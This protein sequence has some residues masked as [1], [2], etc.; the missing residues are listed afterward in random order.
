MQ[1]LDPTQVP[2]DTDYVWN[3]ATF[4]FNSSTAVAT[5][6]DTSSGLQWTSFFDG[7]GNV[8]VQDNQGNSGLIP[9]AAVAPYSPTDGNTCLNAILTAVLIILIVLAILIAIVIVVC[10]ISPPNCARAVLW[11]EIVMGLLMCRLSNYAAAA[12]GLPPPC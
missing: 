11:A 1:M 3:G 10:R 6:T 2:F 12:C 7:N 9:A 8:V 5:A 4:H